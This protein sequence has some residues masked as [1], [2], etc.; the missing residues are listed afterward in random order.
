MILIFKLLFQI[1]LFAY[2]LDI[3]ES[4]IYEKAFLFFINYY[5]TKYQTVFLFELIIYL[6]FLFY[7][8]LFVLFVDDFND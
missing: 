6:F 2:Y 5:F 3:Y 1:F 4:I 8:I 7:S